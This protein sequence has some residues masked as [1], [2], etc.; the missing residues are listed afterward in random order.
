MRNCQKNGPNFNREF[1]TC[2]KT[3]DGSDPEVPARCGFFRS[4][5]G[6]PWVSNLKGTKRPSPSSSDIDEGHPQPPPPKRNALMSCDIDPKSFQFLKEAEMILIRLQ[7]HGKK[8]DKLIEMIDK[9][10]AL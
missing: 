7:E 4:V 3:G 6:N 1:W 8:I 2:V 5:D 9:S 10:N